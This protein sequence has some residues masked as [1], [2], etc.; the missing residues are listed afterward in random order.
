MGTLL[1]REAGCKEDYTASMILHRDVRSCFAENC[2]GIPN[3]SFLAFKFFALAEKFIEHIRDIFLKLFE[4]FP[5]VT[6]VQ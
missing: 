1:I 2:L 4:R 3:Q 5:C 6:L